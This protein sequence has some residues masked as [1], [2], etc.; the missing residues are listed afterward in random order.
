MTFGLKGRAY[1]DRL[2]FD[3]GESERVPAGFVNWGLGAGPARFAVQ[4]QPQPGVL[5]PQ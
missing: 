1:S 4:G 5:L 3:F 2:E